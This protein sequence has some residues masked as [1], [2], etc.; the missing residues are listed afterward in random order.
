M[1]P[2][3]SVP[4][5]IDV[6]YETSYRNHCKKQSASYAEYAGRGET[7]NRIIGL[8]L[9][10]IGG[11]AVALAQAPPHWTAAPEIDPASGASVLVMAA[12]ILILIRG[13]RRRKS[14]SV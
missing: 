12:G 7:M 5:A 13:R 8:A 10:G 2:G 11:V 6:E 14:R 1:M 9:L 3:L 4:L